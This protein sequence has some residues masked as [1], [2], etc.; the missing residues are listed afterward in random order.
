MEKDDMA[1][2][3]SDAPAIPAPSAPATAA[4]VGSYPITLDEFCVLLSRDHGPE[5][6]AGFQ[7][8]ERA[9]GRLKDIEPAYRAR[10][11]DFMTAPA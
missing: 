7:A 2:K 10:F 4:V 1:K 6:V 9:A 8:T 11:A 5:A 3:T